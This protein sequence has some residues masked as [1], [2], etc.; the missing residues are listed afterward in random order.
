MGNL[1]RSENS[2]NQHIKLKHRDLWEKLKNVE[3]QHPQ[4]M[5]EQSDSK[6]QID[7]GNKNNEIEF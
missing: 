7:M 2:L 4:G 6:N 3:N 5:F 1:N